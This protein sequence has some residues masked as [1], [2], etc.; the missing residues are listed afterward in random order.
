MVATSA[1]GMGVDK[2][3]VRLIIHYNLPLSLIDYYQQAG[4]AGRDGG[5]ARCVLLYKKSD[6]NTNRYVIEQNQKAEALDYT[7]HALDEWLLYPLKEAEARDVL[8]LVEARNKVASTI[9]CSQYDTSEWHENL[10]D[11][12]LADAICDRIIYNAYTIQIEGESMRKRK[13]IPE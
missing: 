2:A 6:Y 9:F 8:E 12:T 3:D 5:K 1:F 7:L 10:Y 4:R 11:P 13:G